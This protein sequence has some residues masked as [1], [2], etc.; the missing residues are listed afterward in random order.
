M[1]A[2]GPVKIMPVRAV[3]YFIV[4]NQHVMNLVAALA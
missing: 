1:M 3:D 2:R 4:N